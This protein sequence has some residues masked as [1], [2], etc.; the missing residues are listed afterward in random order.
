MNSLRPQFLY[1]YFSKENFKFFDTWMLRYTPHESFNDPFENSPSEPEKIEKL[2]KKQA[3]ALRATLQ[4]NHAY[5]KEFVKKTLTHRLQQGALTLNVDDYEHRQGTVCLS[6]THDNLLM[7]AHYASDHRGFVVE[8]D[9]DYFFKFADESEEK[10][11][12]F[13]VSRVK[14][15]EMR[16]L[17]EPTDMYEWFHGTHHEIETTKSTHWSYE[18]EWR[19]T[20]PLK[21]AD[22][23]VLG[24]ENG[25]PQRDAS[26]HLIH[27]FPVPKK[28][29]SRIIFGA[30]TS[31]E[32]LA[33]VK[34]SIKADQEL[35][36]VQLKLATPDPVD[37]RLRFINIKAEDLP[38][39]RGPLP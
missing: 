13:E 39:L 19:M 24:A 37:F 5:S 16:V 23:V 25:N 30:R 36:H 35:A 8:F 27:L 26:N 6:E 34:K 7:W 31:N 10:I 29:I 28:Y 32:N 3:A 22:C 33:F 12:L 1:K 21:D 9:A 38:E 17:D 20:R 14:Y 11:W 2:T 18:Q 4:D 15:R